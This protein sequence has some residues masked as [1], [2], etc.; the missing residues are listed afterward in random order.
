LLT[1]GVVATPLDGM[2]TLPT[3]GGTQVVGELRA[4]DFLASSAISDRS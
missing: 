3:R 2:G 1:R 4:L